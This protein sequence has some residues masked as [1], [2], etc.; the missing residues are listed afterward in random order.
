MPTSDADPMSPAPA[1][2]RWNALVISGKATP[3]MPRM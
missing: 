3:M 2:L 1:V